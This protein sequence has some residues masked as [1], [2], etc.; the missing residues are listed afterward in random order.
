MTSM[1]GSFS[2]V[3]FRYIRVDFNIFIRKMRKY[4]GIKNFLSAWGNRFSK[5]PYLMEG[6]ISLC[7]GG[8]I[9]IWGRFWP[10]AA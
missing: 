3:E 4:I 10:V 8:V 7:L 6:V 1:A 9:S 2:E 5:K